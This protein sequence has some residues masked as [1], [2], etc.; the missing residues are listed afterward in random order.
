MAGGPRRILIVD[1]NPDAVDSLRVVLTTLGY[2]VKTSH[3]GP[4]ALQTAEDFR[5][6]VI[7]LDIGLPKQSGYEVA[8]QIRKQPWGQAILLVAT[9]GW[10]Q[11][12]DRQRA[13]EAGF[14]HH[15]VK[16]VDSVT[17]EGLFREALSGTD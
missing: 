16:P 10:V 1:D 9:T 17:L 5:P 4:Q 8:R 12:D 11:L 2:E 7:L 14:D 13:H 15:L 6:H 3:D